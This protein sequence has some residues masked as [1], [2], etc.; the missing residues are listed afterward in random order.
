MEPFQTDDGQ[1]TEPIGSQVGVDHGKQRA[2]EAPR[3]KETEF[4]RWI[5][6]GAGVFVTEK[7][8]RWWR[9]D[10]RKLGWGGLRRWGVTHLP[11]SAEEDLAGAIKVDI[12]HQRA[13][14]AV[15]LVAGR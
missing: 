9:E 14:D 12:G 7:L 4:A 8:L 15:V 6:C 11:V 2:G 1:L 5:P 3:P 13:E 10:V